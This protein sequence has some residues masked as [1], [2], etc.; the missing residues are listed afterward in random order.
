MDGTAKTVLHDTALSQPFCLTLDYDT[1][2]LYWADYILNKIEK[3]NADGSNRQLVTTS[4]VINAFSMT[5]FNG[6]LYWTSL[7]HSRIITLSSSSTSSE[8]LTGAFG[9]MHGITALTE[10]RQPSGNQQT[11]FIDFPLSTF[12]IIFIV[13]NP[14]RGSQSNCS[15]FCLLSST[16]ATRYRCGCP[17]GMMLINQ[18][19]CGREYT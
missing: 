16:S 1:Q 12:P 3:S 10:E 5:F 18:T 8:Y 15:H 6:N 7:S 4:L 2:T 11:V 14:C 13:L 9:S 19:N 17:N